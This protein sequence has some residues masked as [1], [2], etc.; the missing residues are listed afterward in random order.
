[1]VWR[2]KLACVLDYYLDWLQD[3]RR[4]DAFYLIW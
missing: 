1:M 2:L 4:V 3:N